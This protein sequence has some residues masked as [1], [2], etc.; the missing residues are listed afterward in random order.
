M[1]LGNPAPLTN[2]ETIQDH[3]HSHDTRT[4]GKLEEASPGKHETIQT[5]NEVVTA[6][7]QSPSHMLNLCIHNSIS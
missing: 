7:D 2:K 3:Y 5:S 1:S 6:I 4:G